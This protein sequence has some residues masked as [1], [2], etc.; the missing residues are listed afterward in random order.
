MSV[1]GDCVL[2]ELRVTWHGSTEGCIRLHWYDGNAWY[3]L[4]RV[5]G[6]RCGGLGHRRVDVRPDLLGDR[7]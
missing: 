1:C 3:D 2:L 7:G 6:W 5:R 4:R